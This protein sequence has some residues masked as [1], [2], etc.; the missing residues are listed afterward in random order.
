MICMT[1]AAFTAFTVING[2]GKADN[3]LSKGSTVFLP[4]DYKAKLTGKMT[5]VAVSV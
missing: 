4:A 2:S 1:T 5:A 3:Y